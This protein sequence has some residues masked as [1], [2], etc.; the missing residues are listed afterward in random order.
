M[1]TKRDNSG[2]QLLKSA[3]PLGSKEQSAACSTRLDLEG[4]GY[5]ELQDLG[6]A[7]QLEMQTISWLC[8]VLLRVPDHPL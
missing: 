7:V 5:S 3:T 1:P 6:L 2:R 8:S 4:L